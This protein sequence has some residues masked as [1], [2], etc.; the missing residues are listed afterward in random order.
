MPGHLGST[1]TWH[2]SCKVLYVL[3]LSMAPTHAPQHKPYLT[4]PTPQGNAG[5][6]PGAVDALAGSA[7]GQLD[8]RGILRFVTDVVDPAAALSLVRFGEKHGRGGVG[9]YN[10]GPNCETWAN[11]LPE[12]PY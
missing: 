3:S 6:A 1:K 9:V 12:N 5:G 8:A 4:L 10:V 11:T 7:F 2:H